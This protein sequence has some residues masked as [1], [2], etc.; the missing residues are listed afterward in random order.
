MGCSVRLRRKDGAHHQF[1]LVNAAILS[2]LYADVRSMLMVLV[3]FQRRSSI[4]NDHLHSQHIEREVSE[5]EAGRMVGATL[6]TTL[7]AVSMFKRAL[8]KTTSEP[9]GV[10]SSSSSSA[11]SLTSRAL[12]TQYANTSI[13]KMCPRI[14]MGAFC[15][16][17]PKGRRRSIPSAHP[18]G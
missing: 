4:S 9:R 1:T 10:G 15:W 7:K 13:K 5:E 17:C 8:R 11:V 6:L 18:F 16:A 14:L 2:S 3:A 12:T